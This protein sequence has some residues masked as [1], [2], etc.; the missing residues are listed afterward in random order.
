MGEDEVLIPRSR[1]GSLFPACE[2]VDDFAEAENTSRSR[3]GS[4][5]EHDLG[6]EAPP[7]Y[8]GSRSGSIIASAIANLKETI[9]E[10]EETLESHSD[11][12]AKK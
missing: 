3:S 1:R 5:I 8:K 4:V 10:V 7:K 11:N 9:S 2:F 12:N 6:I